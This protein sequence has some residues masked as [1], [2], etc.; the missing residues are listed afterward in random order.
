MNRYPLWK[1]LTI[2]V[3]VLIG[4]LYGA[5]NLFSQDPSLEI[6]AV[7]SAPVNEA[8]IGGIKAALENG[9]VPV[10][11]I[12]GVYK[13]RKPVSSKLVSHDLPA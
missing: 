2:L 4:V 8:T 6:S 9:A 13:L 7:R 10:K 11:R 5:P 3:I 1:N 12:E